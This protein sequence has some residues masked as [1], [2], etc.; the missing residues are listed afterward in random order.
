MDHDLTWDIADEPRAGDAAVV[1]AGLESFNLRAADF[2]AIRRLACFARV[3]GSDIIG[4]AVGRYWNEACELQQL[5]VRD[6]YRRSG[7]GARLLR[8]FEDSARQRGC[9]LLYLDTFS[10]QAPNFYR[11]RGFRVACELRGFPDGVSKFIMTR[12]LDEI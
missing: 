12:A 11:K 7:V 4:G 9:K 3:R 6:D 1:D 8:N 2:A 5:W 10:F